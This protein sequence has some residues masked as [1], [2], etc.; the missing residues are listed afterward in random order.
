MP[1]RYLPELLTNY[2]PVLRPKPAPILA[3]ITEGETVEVEISYALVPYLL[4]L[5]EI[6]RWPDRFRGDPA[7]IQNAVGLFQ[8]L[9]VALT[10]G[11]VQHILKFPVDNYNVIT[12]PNG[13]RGL[14]INQA[15]GEYAFVATQQGASAPV[16]LF[17]QEHASNTDPV[18]QLDRPQPNGDYL[19]VRVNSAWNTAINRYGQINSL[20]YNANLPTANQY[21][22]GAII[23]LLNSASPSTNPDGPY[24]GMQ[25]GSAYFWSRFKGDTGSQGTQGPPGNNGT[26]GSNGLPATM[27][28]N[29][30]LTGYPNENPDFTLTPDTAPN[31]N[32]RFAVGVKL[33]RVPTISLNSFLVGLPKD[34]P[35]FTM[36]SD[37]HGDKLVGV[38]MPRAQKMSFLP[39]VT[40]APG[41]N[42][43][44]AYSLDTNGDQVV[45][46][47]I[48]AGADGEGSGSGQLFDSTPPNPGQTKTYSMQVPVTG[49]VIPFAFGKDWTFKVT[50]TRGL[51]SYTTDDPPFTFVG[52]EGD[53]NFS[54]PYTPSNLMEMQA[55]FQ[56]TRSGGTRVFDVKRVFDGTLLTFDDPGNIQLFPAVFGATSLGGYL[57]VDYEVF[58][59]IV[60]RY[61]FYR[62]A[63]EASSPIRYWRCNEISGS[64]LTDAI[65]GQQLTLSGSY[66]LNQVS[67]W[68]GDQARAIHWSGGYAEG[69]NIAALNGNHSFAIELIGKQNGRAAMV[70]LTGAST[71]DNEIQM[72]GYYSGQVGWFGN[73]TN[74]STGA[75]GN[76]NY[77]HFVF[78]YDASTG[79]RKVYMDGSQLVSQSGYSRNGHTGLLTRI[80][81]DIF[82]TS[83]WTGSEIAIYDKNLTAS[84]VSAHYSAYLQSI[85]GS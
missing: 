30:L 79:V 26:N 41:S 4:G 72:V 83:D 21:T 15:G 42:A 78:T 68:I 10:E 55:F 77:H 45:Q 22:V 81:T 69:A 9:R 67:A 37:S 39:A 43:S 34:D 38:K 70:A 84:D 14:W 35:D 62:L 40:G 82:G 48:P 50:G 65:N 20:I 28:L 5:L 18:L 73:G 32:N 12:A 85:A 56:R 80:G 60:L 13:V 25:V 74:I 7:D 33:S 19:Q 75:L 59:A 52:A 76:T 17:A 51:W 8:D 6:Y 11:N 58:A 16:A 31:A 53:I 36:T 49:A 3:S 2:T 66:S 54:G 47:T 46:L 24:I 29:S 57:W 61:D 27:Y 71:G 1:K 63:V 64:V 23:F 44:V